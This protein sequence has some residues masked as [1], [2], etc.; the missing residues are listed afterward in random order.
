MNYLERIRAGAYLDVYRIPAVAGLMIISTACGALVQPGG[1]VPTPQRPSHPEGL[2]AVDAVSSTVRPE[3]R[4]FSEQRMRAQGLENPRGVT[5]TENGDVNVAEREG[6]RVRLLRDT[7]GDGRADVSRIVAEDLNEGLEGVHA[8]AVRQNRLY[9]VTVRELYSAP[10]QADGGLGEP[11]LHIDDIPDGG[12]HPN[13]TM[14]WGPDGMLYLSVGSQTNGVPEHDEESATIL[15]I[16]PANWEREIFAEGLRNTIGFGWHPVSGHLYGLDHNT[17]PKGDNWPP[18]E[19]NRIQ[20]GRHFGWPW[21]GG[22]REVDWHVAQNPE[23]NMSREQFCAQTE[24]PVL[25]Y[26]A[27]AA[28]MQM[29]YYTGNRFPAEYRNDAFVTM[30]GSWNRNPPIGYEVVRIRFNEAGEPV[31]MQPFVSGWLVDGGRAHFG[32][33][34]GLAQA[35][36]G[37]L[38]VGDDSNGVIYRIWYAGGQ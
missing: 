3:R 33:L 17:D 30:R 31:E 10:I 38:L 19:L 36:D 5:V 15:R 14:R 22:N 29:V 34:M 35:A 23:G 27:H 8:F 21:C 13:R 11:E 28:P 18:E 12:Q 16:N 2:I 20:Q 24:P 26:T 9:M 1:Q 32:R 37:S 25:R 7:N 4:D 6:G